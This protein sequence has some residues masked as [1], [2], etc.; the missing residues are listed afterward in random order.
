MVKIL[1]IDDS[2]ELAEFL[3]FL[4]TGKGYEID[5]LSSGYQLQEKLI[6]FNP[7]VILMDV[8]LQ[9]ESG[10]DICKKIKQDRLTNHIP[11]ILLSAD[12]ELLENYTECAADAVIEKPFDIKVLLKAVENVLRTSA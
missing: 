1:I 5:K 8:K 2:P 4:L 6:Q 7:A 10:R 9:N 3:E 11:I 12:P